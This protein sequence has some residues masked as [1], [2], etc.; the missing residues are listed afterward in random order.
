MIARGGMGESLIELLPQLA[1]IIAGAFALLWWVVRPLSFRYQIDGD[2]L[3][4]RNFFIIPVARIPFRSLRS[5]SDP[6]NASSASR[7]VL[8]PLHYRLTA[9]VCY[10][11]AQHEIWVLPD[12]HA[13][14]LGSPHPA[15]AFESVRRRR[16]KPNS[17]RQLRFPGQSSAPPMQGDSCLRCWTKMLMSQRPDKK[18]LGSARRERCRRTGSTSRQTSRRDGRP[19]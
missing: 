9:R 11:E 7:R 14:W 12:W 1:M 5:P 4:V 19:R 13:G 17:P 6:S 18:R 10:A 2:D 3:I 8:A 16:L 15:A